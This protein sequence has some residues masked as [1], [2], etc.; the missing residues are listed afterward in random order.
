MRAIHFEFAYDITTGLTSQQTGACWC[1]SKKAPAAEPRHRHYFAAPAP[2]FHARKSPCL[3]LPFLSC[4]NIYFFF[5]YLILSPMTHNAAGA[6]VTQRM[7]VCVVFEKKRGGCHVKTASRPFPRTFSFV[8]YRT[9]T[10]SVFTLMIHWF[11]F[12]S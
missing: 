12:S 4:S 10:S 3:P 1:R 8:I 5:F 2:P 11:V 6:S 7:P 9:G